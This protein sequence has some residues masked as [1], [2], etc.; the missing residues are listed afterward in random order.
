MQPKG[1]RQLRRE[2]A[3]PRPAAVQKDRRRPGACG[4][5][6]LRLRRQGVQEE[7]GNGPRAATAAIV[8][9][10]YGLPAR[11]AQLSV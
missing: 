10:A 2:A 7:R 8:G 4:R 11:G 3:L 9:L 6:P 5:V 1:S